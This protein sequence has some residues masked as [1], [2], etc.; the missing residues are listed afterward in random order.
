MRP[1]KWK[2]FLPRPIGK[3]QRKDQ[4]V[5]GNSAGDTITVDT[6]H[7]K[8]RQIIG[9]LIMFLVTYSCQWDQSRSEL[10]EKPYSFHTHGKK[11]FPFLRAYN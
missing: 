11:P 3:P 9:R 7:T 5:A 2:K 4:G 1:G 6:V 10:C 8:L